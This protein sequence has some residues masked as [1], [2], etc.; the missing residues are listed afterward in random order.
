MYPIV[1]YSDFRIEWNIDSKAGDASKG[2]R[3][4]AGVDNA[5][6]QLPPFG[7]TATGV[8]TAIYNFRGRSFYAGARARF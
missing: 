6:N 1:T 8:G 5:F 7:S 4:Y 3:F 2:L